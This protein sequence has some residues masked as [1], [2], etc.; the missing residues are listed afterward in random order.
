MIINF[1]QIVLTFYSATN[2]EAAG[3]AQIEEYFEAGPSVAK[4]IIT[5]GRHKVSTPLRYKSDQNDEEIELTVTKDKFYVGF[6]GREHRLASLPRNKCVAI[7]KIKS[8]DKDK[9]SNTI[10]VLKSIQRHIN[11]EN[12]RHIVQ[13][14]DA[15]YEKATNLLIIVSELGD[16]TLKERL[17]AENRTFLVEEMAMKIVVPL[18]ELHPVAM[19][20]DIKPCNYV[21]VKSDGDALKLIDFDGADLLLGFANVQ[22]NQS[23]IPEV[24]AHTKQYMSPEQD[25]HIF[26]RRR[27]LSVKADIWAIGIIIYEIILQHKYYDYLFSKEEDLDVNSVLYFI[28][29]YYRGYQITGDEDNEAVQFDLLDFENVEWLLADKYYDTLA[30]IL[31]VAADYPL[32]FH[33]IIPAQRMSARGIVDFLNKKCIPT[34]SQRI[35]NV[36]SL[37]FFQNVTVGRLR[38]IFEAQK[39]QKILGLLNIVESKQRKALNELNDRTLICENNNILMNASV[40]ETVQELVEKSPTSPQHQLS[41][42]KRPKNKLKKILSKMPKIDWTISKTKFGRLKKL[43]REEGDSPFLG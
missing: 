12:R 18:L 32:L 6:T 2:V 42:A 9:Y 37:P 39:D 3:N 30:H 13:L 8:S 1:L 40:E 21:F 41:D 28:G 24:V 33:L 7:K 5:C 26:K 4:A 16:E 35:N 15:G 27:E 36:P 38:I 29:N 34:T 17:Y 22:Q 43:A 25:E 20:L 19:H 31:R 14:F 11:A 23:K 10:R